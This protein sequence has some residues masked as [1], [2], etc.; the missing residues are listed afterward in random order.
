MFQHELRR[1][2]RIMRL[3]EVEPLH[4]IALHHYQKP[5]V[6]FRL[7]AFRDDVQVKAVRKRNDGAAYRYVVA[8]FL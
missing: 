8:A 4:L 1:C 7:H 5:F 3:G 6:F 2:R